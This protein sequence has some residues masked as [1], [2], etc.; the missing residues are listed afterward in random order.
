MFRVHTLDYSR[1]T[2]AEHPRDLPE[3][4]AGL[5]K[6]CGSGVPECVR[7]TLSDQ[8]GVWPIQVRSLSR[9]L[10]RLPQR[11]YR[12][13][14]IPNLAETVPAVVPEFVAIGLDGHCH[15]TKAFWQL[16]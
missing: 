12:T 15:G 5:G 10:E 2:V 16:Q 3:V 8:R 14:R 9:D 11:L 6:P 7:D 1:V 13:P 4:D